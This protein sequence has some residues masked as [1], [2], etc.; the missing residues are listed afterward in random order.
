[1]RM[2]LRPKVSATFT[3]CPGA[4]ALPGTPHN[5]RRW[6]V[7]VVLGILIFFSHKYNFFP[8]VLVEFFFLKFWEKEVKLIPYYVL[9]VLSTRGHSG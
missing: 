2:W 8:M 7:V 6:W 5:P 4:S 1:M 3:M 9:E